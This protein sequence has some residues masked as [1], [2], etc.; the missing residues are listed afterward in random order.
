MPG[1]RRLNNLFLLK[2]SSNINIILKPIL[3]PFLF[4]TNI[5]EIF[6]REIVSQRCYKLSSLVLKFVRK[7]FHHKID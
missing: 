4:K 2:N 6:F 1:L 5:F 7:S 3:D